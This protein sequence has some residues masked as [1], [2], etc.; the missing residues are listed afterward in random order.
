MNKLTNLKLVFMVMVLMITN[1]AMAG[2][3]MLTGRVY[4]SVTHTLMP[5]GNGS[6]AI[7][8]ETVGIVA[9]G[10]DSP[11]VYK[12]TCIGLGIQ[13]TK[14]K[15]TNNVYCTFKRNE[16]DRFDIEAKLIDGKGNLKV[17]GGSGRYAGATGKGSYVGSVEGEKSL[18]LVKFKIKTN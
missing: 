16:N 13:D 12:L 8:N 18:G 17:I 9:M 15:F 3:E 1:T 14:D 4:A 11:M 7:D 2:T 10:G 5:L 6:A